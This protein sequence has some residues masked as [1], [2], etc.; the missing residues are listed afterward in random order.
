MDKARR[1]LT[2]P[3][4]GQRRINDQ[5]NYPR[6]Q[7][8]VENNVHQRARQRGAIYKET[9]SRNHHYTNVEKR[10]LGSNGT[11]PGACSRGH[12]TG[13]GSQDIYGTDLGRVCR[14]DHR[15]YFRINNRHT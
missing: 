13:R 3:I 2:G 7:V 5:C 4:V 8:E 15:R 11:A 9:T 14:V 10:V 6:P 1:G 12:C